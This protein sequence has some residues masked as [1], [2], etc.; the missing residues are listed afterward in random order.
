MKRYLS[1]TGDLSR[2][3]E[4]YE[5]NVQLSEAMY[6]L[7]HGLEIAVRNAEH[8]ALTASFGTPYWYE[9]P[10]TPGYGMPPPGAHGPAWHDHAQLSP[11]WMDQISKAKKKPG[12][13]SN[14]GKLI[15]ELTFRFWVDLIQAGNH[16]KLWVDRKLNV[17]F[18]NARRHRQLV[19][20]RLTAIY[21]LRNRI[22]HH[23][24]VLT[25]NNGLYTGDGIIFLPQVLEC[26]EWVCAD[27]AQWMRTALHYVEAEQILRHVAGM[28]VCL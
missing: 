23:E 20:E 4:L 8:H 14:P 3:L 2:A 21:L 25:S 17:A 26:V 19:H 16:R 6:G 18:P 27:T 7:L 24:P 28:G 9:G 15:A 22:A 11:Y 10:P 12:V 5:Y 13:G 1:A